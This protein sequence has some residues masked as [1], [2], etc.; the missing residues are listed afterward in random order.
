MKK[1]PF[2]AEEIQDEAILCKHCGSDILTEEVPDVVPAFK[3][4]KS[5][6][7]GACILGLFLISVTFWAMQTER[8]LEPAS[9]RVGIVPSQGTKQFSDDVIYFSSAGGYLKTANGE[10]I[11]LAKVIAGGTNGSSTLGD[12]KNA[13]SDAIQI[14]G[15]GYNLDYL[16]KVKGK[17][18]ESASEVAPEIEE[19]HRLFQSSLKECLE[20][21]NDQNVEHLKSG[22]DSFRRT[23][24][25]M[26]QAIE[27][28]N[29]MHVKK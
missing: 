25:V 2:C 20:Y 12:M 22:T 16:N 17:I 27:S 13:M 28:L 14:E 21:W 23:I 15:I 6:L 11:R 26:N 24:L 5:F 9:A 29:R 1:C 8:E 19:T 3:A 7:I 18:P 10:G 4:R